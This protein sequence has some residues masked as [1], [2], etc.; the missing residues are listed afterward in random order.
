MPKCRSEKNKIPDNFKPETSSPNIAIDELDKSQNWFM[1]YRISIQKK[2]KNLGYYPPVSD[3]SK[4]ASNLWRNEEVG[5]KMIYKNLALDAKNQLKQGHKFLQQ[6][7]TINPPQNDTIGF[8]NQPQYN[9]SSPVDN[10]NPFQDNFF[11]QPM[12]NPEDAT[13]SEEVILQVAI[14]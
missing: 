8:N 3:I 11:S 7:P 5:I 6:H 12:S 9:V 1:V 14:I 10:I 4:F 2:L 13:T